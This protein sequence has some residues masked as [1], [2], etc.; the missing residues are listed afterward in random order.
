MTK[1]VIIRPVQTG[2]LWVGDNELNF[3]DLGGIRIQINGKLWV[4]DAKTEKE[5]WFKLAPM[6]GHKG[7][8]NYLLQWRKRNKLTQTD[9]AKELGLS[10]SM[11]AKIENG[12]RTMPTAV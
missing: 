11:I 10:Q 9:T 4:Y 2:K 5:L 7:A 8:V 12:T 1:P 3:R 6:G